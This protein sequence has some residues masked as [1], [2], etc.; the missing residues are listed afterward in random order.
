MIDNKNTESLSAYIGKKISQK[1]YN[2]WKILMF[3]L[4]NRVI[5][6]DDCII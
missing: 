2:Y 5:K 1:R 4:R 3:C 6:I